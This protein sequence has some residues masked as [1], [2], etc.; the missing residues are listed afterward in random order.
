LAAAC[1]NPTWADASPSSFTPPTGAIFVT[2][3]NTVVPV[4]STHETPIQF[5]LIQNANLAIYSTMAMYEPQALDHFLAR[6]S[7]RLGVSAV[8]AATLP[9]T[10]KSLWP[11]P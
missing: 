1:N 8:A 7:L 5:R 6:P 11:T 4:I 2:F 10:D 9:S 3:I